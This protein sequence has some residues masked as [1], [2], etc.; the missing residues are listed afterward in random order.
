MAKFSSVAANPNHRH[1]EEYISRKYPIPRRDNE[2]RSEFWR[3]YNRL[4]HAKAYRRL[5]HKTQVFFAVNNDHV[6]TRIEHVNHVSAVSYSMAKNLGLDTE[7]VLAIAIGHDIGHPP[8][9]HDGEVLLRNIAK[10]HYNGTFWHEQN[11]L[12]FADNI[13]Y[14]QN[15]K[16]E[17]QALNLTYAVR[18]GIISHCGEVDEQAIF[19]R[20]EFIELENIERPNQYNP[21]TWEACIVKAAD[22]ISYL[23]R[24]LEDAIRL[25]IIQK[26]EQEELQDILNSYS[27][28]PITNYSNTTLIHHFAT[29]LCL[30]SSPESGILFSE[31]CFETITRIKQFNYKNIYKHPRLNVFKNYAKL[32]VHSIFDILNE[33]YGNN[34]A[35]DL[36]RKKLLYPKLIASFEKWLFT[37]STLSAERP[38]RIV[39]DISDRKSYQ[40]CIVGF[41]ASMSDFFAL[42]LFEE[43][44]RFE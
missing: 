21:C 41:I 18:D 20:K 17:N 29:D 38:F 36:H 19:P 9:G 15:E 13:E 27:D 16:G 30:N 23:G 5:K 40:R 12:F 8:F 26:E 6:C 7:L 44:I 32:V 31:K 2:I 1:W 37:Y 35:E 33:L 25:K 34:I 11:G 14:L 28:S 42:E 4:L 24:D 22:K 3:D 10:E 39:Y 43:L